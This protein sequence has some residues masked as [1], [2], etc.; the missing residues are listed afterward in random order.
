M[1]MKTQQIEAPTPAVPR[2][3]GSR[4]LDVFCFHVLGTAG[5]PRNAPEDPI[6]SGR[7]IEQHQVSQARHARTHVFCEAQATPEA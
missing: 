4:V 1:H 6:S 3:G 5:G 2:H 7:A